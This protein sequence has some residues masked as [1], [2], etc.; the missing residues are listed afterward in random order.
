MR[1][2]S[3]VRSR[4]RATLWRSRLEREMDAE[5]RFHLEAYAEDLVRSGVP[6][7]EAMR[8]ARLEFGGVERAKEEC[9]DAKGANVI[10]SSVQDIRYGLRMLL[11]SPGFSAVAILTLALGIGANS[12]IFSIV[13]GVL[14][15]PLP[16]RDPGRLTMVWEKNERG[17]PGNATFA[18]YTDWKAMNH[19][20]EELALYRSW[21]PTVTGAG[22]PEELSGLRVTNNYFRTLGI[23]PEL[24]RDFRTEEDVP[25]ASHV[26]ILGHGLWQRRFNSDPGIIGKTI[27]LNAASYVVVGVLSA[28]FQSLISRD[29]RA[30]PVEIWGALGYDAS[31]PWACRTCHHLVAIGRLLPGVT[32]TQA[33]AEMDT[34]SAALWKAYPDAY[35]ASGVILTPLREELLAPVSAT[36]YVLLGAVTFVLLVACANLANLLLARATHREKE[37]AVRAALGAARGRIVRQLLAENCLL[38]LLGAAAGLVPAYWTPRLLSWLG[39]GGLPRL[40]EVRLDWRV[41][42]FTFGLALLTGVVSGMVPALRLS[43]ANLQDALNE[44]ARGSAGVASGRLRGMLVVSEVALSLTLLVGAGLLLRSLAH[45]LSV[46]PGF[47]A[48]HVLTMRISVIGPKYDDNGNLRR[49]FNDALERIRALPGVKV[50]GAASEIPLGGNMDQYGFHAEGKINANPELDP[51][52]ERYCVSPGYR[53]AMQIPLLL[54]RD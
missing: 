36:L 8:R 28:E 32:F 23:R 35:S 46:S 37:M 52:A 33:N 43:K 3:R 24:G 11:K 39:T 22:E 26:V 17:Q 7:Q 13:N 21:S 45:L 30:G 18:T 44:S 5:L 54:G 50:A 47:E 15:R 31:L 6:R 19:S 9:R 41:F 49:F 14:L 25:S 29:P 16:Y 40:A 1:F 51:S 4:L 38:A 12:A 27:E 20:F 42:L 34:I 2:W 53:S 10:E 48:S